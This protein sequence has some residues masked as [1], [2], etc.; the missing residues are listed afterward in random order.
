MA[1]SDDRLRVYNKN[2]YVEFKVGETLQRLTLFQALDGDSSYFVP[3]RDQTSGKETYGAGRYVEPKL[4]KNGK[5]VVDFNTAYNPYCAYN[6]K[7]SCP[8]PPFE[9]S[10]QVKIEAGEKLFLLKNQ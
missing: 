8:L 9:N 2:V 5:V 6:C 3:F 1:T 7:Y 4:L 10:L